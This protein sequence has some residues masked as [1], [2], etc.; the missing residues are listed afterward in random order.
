MTS[1]R[2]RVELW[3]LLR[4]TLPLVTSCLSSSGIVRED[5]VLCD[6]EE[7]SVLDD[8]RSCRGSPDRCLWSDTI[9][10]YTDCFERR[11]CRRLVI[12][13]R[14][15]GKYNSRFSAV[16]SSAKHCSR[17]VRRSSGTDTSSLGEKISKCRSTKYWT[18]AM[19]ILNAAKAATAALKS[20]P[21]R[22]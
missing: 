13:W 7:R 12:I 14:T 8:I 17:M 19:S 22:T 4:D 5:C 15:S 21:R 3:A 9:L 20:F 2:L 10:R 18:H 1:L 6:R 11:P 16:A